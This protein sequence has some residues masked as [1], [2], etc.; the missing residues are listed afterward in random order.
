[1]SSQIIIK[2]MRMQ[3]DIVNNTQNSL[4]KKNSDYANIEYDSQSGLYFYKASQK[5]VICNSI[6]FKKDSV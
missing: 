5:C 4:T 3:I 6:K 2:I 1:M